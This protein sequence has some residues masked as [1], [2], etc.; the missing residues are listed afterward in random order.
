MSWD[1]RMFVLPGSAWLVL[2][3]VTVLGAVLA[4][5]DPSARGP[6]LRWWAAIAAAVLLVAASK[7]A[8][9]GWGTGVRAWDLTCFSG[10]TVLGLVFWPVALALLVPPRYRGWRVSMAAAGW[11]FAG[12][13]G[14]SR[15]MLRAH[16]LSEVLAGALLGVIAG[17]YGLHVLRRHRWPRAWGT[18]VVAVCLLVTLWL[19]PRSMHL[20]D[21]ERWFAQIGATLAGNEKPVSRRAFKDVKSAPSRGAPKVPP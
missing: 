21:S 1:W 11:V 6:V 3:L 12:L 15:V 19:D 14:A 20:P 8:F 7:I 10:H 2:P 18:G 17:G 16:P 9:Y 5:R 4:G 13:I